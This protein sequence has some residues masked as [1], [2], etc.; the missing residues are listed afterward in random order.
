MLPG[1][2]VAGELAPGTYENLPGADFHCEALGATY[3]VDT[4]SDYSGKT[5]LDMY[6]RWQDLSRTAETASKILDLIWTD[7][8]ANSVAGTRSIATRSEAKVKRA[9]DAVNSNS[10]TW[11][12]IVYQKAIR[13]HLPYGIPAFMLLFAGACMCSI[14][15]CFIIVGRTGPS[16]MRKYLNETS[17]GRV[18]A[19]HVYGFLGEG[20]GSVSDEHSSREWIERVGRKH[21][22]I[23][24]SAP[25]AVES[26]TVKE[27]NSP[28]DK[29][30]AGPLLDT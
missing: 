20:D 14:T 29:S 24:G 19:A 1:F 2:V 28:M 10:N 15:L 4:D 11:P 3:N 12:V 23:G 5:N 26:C 30:Q 17:V 7:V 16:K 18:L 8:A 21:I 13:Y 27:E 6:R 9:D 22:I 25:V